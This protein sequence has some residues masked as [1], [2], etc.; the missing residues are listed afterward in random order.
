M[1][2]EAVRV[3]AGDQA[4]RV[5]AVH[6][7]VDCEVAAVHE[8]YAVHLAALLSR[9]VPLERHERVVIVR[10]GAALARDRLD[11]M[12]ER[13]LG[14]RALLEPLAVEVHH[15]VVEVRQLKAGAVHALEIHRRVGIVLNDC[16]ARHHRHVAVHRVIELHDGAGRRVARR[17]LKRLAVAV[18][19]AQGGHA[20]QRGLFRKDAVGDVAD[21]GGNVAVFVAD[22]QR[23]NAE[24][25]GAGHGILA[26]RHVRRDARRD[27]VREIRA[28]G[29]EHAA[30]E[31]KEQVVVR[32]I[33]AVIEV[34]EIP[35]LVHGESIRCGR[36]IEL[37]DF[38]GSVKG[39]GHNTS[40]FR[41]IQRSCFHYSG[42]VRRAQ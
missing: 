18:L 4:R 5:E 24:I 3:D 32:Q 28:E 13:A 17:D 40:P 33:R 8:V 21:V 19:V 10:G 2:G 15:V 12:A 30:V 38:S 41:K 39:D 16:A 31:H 25:A 27:I 22:L 6:L 11:A 23:G 29:G 9:A 36:R 26:R 14:D 35:R 20:A 34:E 42:F 37:E 7:H 1:P